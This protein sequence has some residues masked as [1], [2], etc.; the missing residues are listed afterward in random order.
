M[1]RRVHHTRLKTTLRAYQKSP[2]VRIP[3]YHH[4]EPEASRTGNVQPIVTLEKTHTHPIKPR[5]LHANSRVAYATAFDMAQATIDALPPFPDGLHTAPIAHISSKRLL[6]GDREEGKRVLEACQTSG[7][8]YLD[9]TDS[10]DGQRLIDEAEGCL[11]LAKRSFAARNEDGH[12]QWHL[13]KGVSMFGYKAAGT[14]KKT[15]ENH[16]YEAR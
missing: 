6:A 13:V 10:S 9:L 8:F 3:A 14:K 4:F 15:D 5:Y 12:K 1:I 16:K 2:R 11:E 7:F